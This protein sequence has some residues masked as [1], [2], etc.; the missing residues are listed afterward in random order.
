MQSHTT[1]E[2]KQVWLYIFSSSSQKSGSYKRICC[3]RIREMSDLDPTQLQDVMTPNT[4]TL[5]TKLR[6]GEPSYRG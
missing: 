5:A 1:Q 6:A 2:R 3:L 4:N